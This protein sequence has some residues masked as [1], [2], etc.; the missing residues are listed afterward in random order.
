MELDNEYSVRNI[1]LEAFDYPKVEVVI[2]SD[3]FNEGGSVNIEA[4]TPEGYRLILHSEKIE[5]NRDVTGEREYAQELA[6]NWNKDCKANWQAEM[7]RCFEY[8]ADHERTQIEKL[9]EHKE[10]LAKYE[11]AIQR[12]KAN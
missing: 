6:D 7:L 1:D 5:E 9:D 2:W 8:I 10:A 11:V 3:A 4:K 12:L